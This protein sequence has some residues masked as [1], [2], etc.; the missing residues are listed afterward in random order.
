[1]TTT[2]APAAASPPAIAAPIPFEAPV[3]IATLPL[4]S[5]MEILLL[6]NVS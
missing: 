1:L 5:L 2:A 4:S 6:A 3:T